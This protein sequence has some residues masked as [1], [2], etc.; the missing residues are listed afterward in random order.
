MN[1]I[2]LAEESVRASLLKKLLYLS[3]L[4][5]CKWSLV[6]KIKTHFQFIL[7]N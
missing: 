6:I 1:S 3:A 5:C 4:H 2:E 7:M